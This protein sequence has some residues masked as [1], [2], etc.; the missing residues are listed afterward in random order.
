MPGERARERMLK[1]I[2]ASAHELSVVYP[3]LR[4]AA[5]GVAPAPAVLAPLTGPRQPQALIPPDPPEPTKPPVEGIKCLWYDVHTIT[6]FTDVLDRRQYGTAGWR[7]GAHALA[8]VAVE[9]TA[10][11]ST[12]PYGATVFDDCEAVVH[13]ENTYRV[14][15]LERYNA[16]DAVPYSYYLWLGTSLGQ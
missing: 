5:S 8:C 12:K 9:D 2:R 14:L 7:Q 4:V 11:D 15:E 16:G 1:R 10:V 6:A 13:A 3:P